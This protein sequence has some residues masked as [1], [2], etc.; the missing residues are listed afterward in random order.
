MKYK[1]DIVID[2][3]LEKVIELFNSTDNLFKWQQGLIS[4]DHVSG[5]PGKKNA[6]SKLKYKMGKR[7]IDMTETIEE[8]N[9]PDTF[10]ARY[11]AKGVTNWVRNNFESVDNSK[12]KWSTYHEFKLKGGIKI[13]GWLFPKKFKQQSY[14]FMEDFK[15]FAESN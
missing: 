15:R 2:Q 5:E 3:P 7:E 10:S 11:E 14:S 9:L 12:T 4:F 1:L 8:M 13:F 6:V